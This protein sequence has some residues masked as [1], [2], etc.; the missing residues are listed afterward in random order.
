MIFNSVTGNEH[1]I[2]NIVNHFVN[3]EILQK[4]LDVRDLDVQL[5]PNH[6]PLPRHSKMVVY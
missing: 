5:I 3:K 4:I 2:T 6:L 1:Y